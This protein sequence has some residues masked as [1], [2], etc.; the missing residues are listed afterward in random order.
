MG[1]EKDKIG[2]MTRNAEEITGQ[3]QDTEEGWGNFMDLL[4]NK[5]GKANKKPDG[6]KTSSPRRLDAWD[7]L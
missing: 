7:N 3:S 5:S 6:D 4:S 1:S 2:C